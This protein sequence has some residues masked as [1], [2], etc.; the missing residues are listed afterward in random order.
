MLLHN[1][2]IMGEPTTNTTP[3]QEEAPLNMFE[4]KMGRRQVI[5]GFLQLLGLK[6]A[7]DA[8]NAMAQDPAVAIATPNNNPRTVGT[9]EKLEKT[10]FEIKV[11]WILDQINSLDS[12]FKEGKINVDEYKQALESLIKNEKN[13]TDETIR[14]WN[15]M[16]GSL[17]KAFDSMQDSNP[18]KAAIKALG[19]EITSLTQNISQGN[20]LIKAMRLLIKVSERFPQETLL[21][22][23]T[24]LKNIITQIDKRSDKMITW[25]DSLGKE[26]GKVA[27]KEMLWVK[28]EI[29]DLMGREGSVEIKGSNLLKN[30]SLKVKN[31][32]VEDWIASDKKSATVESRKDQCTVSLMPDKGYYYLK[33]ILKLQPGEYILK[34]PVISE[35]A[36]WAWILEVKVWDDNKRIKRGENNLFVFEFKVDKA[37]VVEVVVFVSTSEVKKDNM[38]AKWTLQATYG[39]VEL[40]KK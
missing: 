35:N 28:D 11:Q 33:Q 3:G 15:K 12:Q 14:I 27:T 21:V 40:K 31:G 17:K 9:P 19:M 29:T 13:V 18:K 7:A 5:G 6:V 16:N 22:S 20:N 30:P 1:H 34:L 8:T 23:V 4:G 37:Q 38:P 36:V 26:W 39:T 2:K 25:I 32:E 24:Y 10:W